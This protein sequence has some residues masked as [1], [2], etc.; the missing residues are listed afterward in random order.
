M[1]ISG[2]RR[3]PGELRIRARGMRACRRQ[4]QPRGINGSQYPFSYIFG[5]Q[6][7]LRKADYYFKRAVR[8][9]S[10]VE[11]LICGNRPDS[12]SEGWSFIEEITRGG[13]A[14]ALYYTGVASLARPNFRHALD[15]FDHA[16]SKGFEPARIL[17]ISFGKIGGSDQARCRSNGCK[18]RHRLH[19]W[20]RGGI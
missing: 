1:M 19:L 3:L 16:G 5:S 11:N 6:D 12:L 14:A 15:C 7:D 8:G 4:R 20:H 10:I 9:R 13:V 2:E 18:R 17:A